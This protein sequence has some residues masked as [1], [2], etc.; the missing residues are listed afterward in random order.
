[1]RFVTFKELLFLDL[2]LLWG[3]TGG[4]RQNMLLPISLLTMG[5]V[6]LKELLFLNLRLL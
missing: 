3:F 4:T 6:T 5:I 2:R 1:M